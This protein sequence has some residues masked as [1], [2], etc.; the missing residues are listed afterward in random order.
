MRERALGY[1]LGKKLH[2]SHLTTRS[3]GASIYTAT[4]F[5]T[6]SDSP[7]CISCDLLLLYTQSVN[8]QKDKE[9]MRR[10]YLT[11][12]SQVVLIGMDCG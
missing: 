10:P 5:F 1:T 9:G 8:V 11:G 7:P 6:S 12:M 2:V 3:A 4:E